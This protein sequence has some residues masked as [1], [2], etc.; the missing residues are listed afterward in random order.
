ML[1]EVIAG[2]GIGEGLDSVDF[3]WPERVSCADTNMRRQSVSTNG[4]KIHDHSSS[5][6][7]AVA[8]WL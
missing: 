8:H 6:R 1:K 7:R 3:S 5:H 4:A 2:F